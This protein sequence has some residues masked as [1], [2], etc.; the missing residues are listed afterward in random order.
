LTSRP[1]FAQ[2]RPSTLVRVS[3]TGAAAFGIANI[4][5]LITNRSSPQLAHGRRGL[6]QPPQ[7]QFCPTVE[8]SQVLA[9]V[10]AQWRPHRLG[11]G[12][13]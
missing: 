11:A 13:A 10:G 4:A 8:R 2:V 6:P 3:A 7:Y 1:P 9:A 5:R 12:P